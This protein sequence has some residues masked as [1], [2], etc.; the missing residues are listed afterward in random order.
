METGFSGVDMEK[1]TCTSFFWYWLR[2]QTAPKCQLERPR[3]GRLSMIRVIFA[4]PF[5]FGG[6]FRMVDGALGIQEY[7]SNLVSEE[8]V[9]SLYLNV[10]IF[11]HE[12]N[13]FLTATEW[14]RQ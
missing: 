4:T 13:L 14:A 10:K 2:A 8:K 7:Q 1:K 12:C 3:S 6:G 9:Y 5:R 11:L